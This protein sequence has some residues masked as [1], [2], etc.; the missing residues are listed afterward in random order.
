MSSDSIAFGV[1]K[2]VLADQLLNHDSL[3]DEFVCKICLVHIVGC[4]P[5]L[6][7]CSH[8]FCGDCLEQWST[9]HQSNKTWA[10][11]TK[12]LSTVPC[13][14]CREP[15]E[16]SDIYPV[17][18]N[19]SGQNASLWNLIQSLEVRCG[20]QHGTACGGNCQCQWTGTY[21]EYSKHLEGDIVLESLPTVHESPE[22]DIFSVSTSPRASI[23]DIAEL[24]TDESAP[25]G[26]EHGKD[27]DT[28][29]PAQLPQ[30]QHQQSPT[31][32][33]DVKLGLDSL[34]QA[35]VDLKINETTL[36]PRLPPGLEDLEPLPPQPQ[37]PPGFLENLP[38]HQAPLA[39]V[40]DEP[41]PTQKTKQKN[42]QKGR[43][44]TKADPV[45]DSGMQAQAQALAFQKAMASQQAIY[46][47]QWQAMQA[48]QMA[49]AGQLARYQHIAAAAQV[50]QMQRA[51]SMQQGAA[52][53]QHGK[54]L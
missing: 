17:N 5:K 19:E 37:R 33:G 43:K 21:A 23:G 38:P 30:V 31:N 16:K 11:R 29:E 53:Y 22:E 41:Q 26:A 7:K 10:Q 8:L 34:I 4:G 42:K 25:D 1:E 6:T 32:T 28:L 44:A 45:S 49:Y 27:I 2:K 15:L 12:A 36:R 39:V 46:Y 3:T 13:P 51:S 54:R 20:R 14:V 40:V 24:S 47:Q 18:G 9:Q 48:A 50:A 35:L 52:S